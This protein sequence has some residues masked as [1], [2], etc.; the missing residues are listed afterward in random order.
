MTPG[1]HEHMSLK[2]LTREQTSI[3]RHIVSGVR[4]D[5]VIVFEVF[6][7]SDLRTSLEAFYALERTWRSMR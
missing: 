4:P 3:L 5:A 6:S 7:E 1:R 2:K